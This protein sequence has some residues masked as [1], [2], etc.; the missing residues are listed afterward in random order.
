MNG[1]F[2][3]LIIFAALNLGLTLSKHGESRASE[4]H[5]IW[6]TLIGT[7]IQLFVTYMAIVIGL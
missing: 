5:N 1:W 6:V 4:K 2:L 3:T 7:S